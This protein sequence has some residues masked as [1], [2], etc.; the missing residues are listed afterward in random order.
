MW[1]KIM[2]LAAL[3]PPSNTTFLRFSVMKILLTMKEGMHENN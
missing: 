2:I 3:P 1:V